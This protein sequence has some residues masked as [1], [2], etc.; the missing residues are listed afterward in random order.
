VGELGNVRDMDAS[1]AK[2][3]LGWETRPVVETILDT[4]RDMI[5]L[6]LVKV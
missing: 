5:R 6:G 2:T 1:H 3:V 4:A